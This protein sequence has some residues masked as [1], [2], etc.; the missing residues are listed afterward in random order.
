ML[1]LPHTQSPLLHSHD[2]SHPPALK[3]R[4]PFHRECLLQLTSHQPRDLGANSFP[5]VPSSPPPPAAS[6]MLAS[7]L[8]CLPRSLP[9]AAS[10][11]THVPP[12]SPAC[13]S[14]SSLQNSLFRCHSLAQPLGLCSQGPLACSAAPHPYPSFG[15]LS[16]PGLF[17]ASP[18]P[19]DHRGPGGHLLSSAL[20]GDTVY[21]E[22]VL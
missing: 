4:F 10:H 21:R 5:S 8:H 3:P 1:S 15:A 16:S 7:L 11:G 2:A 9:C 6:S 19:V 17:P 12:R 20:L 13:P 14:S 22:F 18:C